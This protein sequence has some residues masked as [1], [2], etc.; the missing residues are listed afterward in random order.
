M[1]VDEVEDEFQRQISRVINS[2]I[3]D[4][5]LEEMESY[6]LRLIK[7]LKILKQKN[8]ENEK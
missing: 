7:S 3:Y 8:Q 5:P 4:L 6:V 1:K 2:F